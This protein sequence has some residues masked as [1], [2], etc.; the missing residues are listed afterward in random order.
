M[1]TASR[2]DPSFMSFWVRQAGEGRQLR[3]PPAPA[4]GFLSGLFTPSPSI[5][6][7]RPSARSPH[8]KTRHR[9][10]QGPHCVFL[11]QRCILCP[12]FPPCR[13]AQHHCVSEQQEPPP[14]SAHVP[15]S[16]GARCVEECAQLDA[17]MDA[18][19]GSNCV[20]PMTGT[21]PPNYAELFQNVPFRYP[22]SVFPESGPYTGLRRRKV[23][24]VSKQCI[25]CAPGLAWR[26]RQ[27]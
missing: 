9:K 8:R 4:T 21:A 17:E 10:V 11:Q 2:A 25:L 14:P 7:R 12:S 26:Y 15:F 6:L 20:K 5:H 16:H 13:M 1:L 19:S 27:S 23:A 18:P 22:S 3:A 24:S